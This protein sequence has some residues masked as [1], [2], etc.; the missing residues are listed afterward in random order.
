MTAATLQSI[1]ITAPN[2]SIAKGT[3]EQF[4]ATGTYSDASTANITSQVSWNSATP[5][6][7]TISTTGLAAG[8]G[9]GSSHI[10]A[11]LSGV[12]SNIFTL[13][14]TPATLRSIAI[15]ALNSSI[16]KGT[17][18]QFTATGTY[19]DASTAN[20]T[21]QV[22]W[23]SATPAVVTIS[24]TGLASGV[25]T[26]SSNITATLSSVTSNTFTL[27][28]LPAT[29]RSIAIT[30]PNTS[31]GKGI[32]EQFTATGTYSDASTAN[33]TSLA[34][35]NSATP[36]VVTISAIGLAS[37]VSTG[38][39]NI[40]ATLSSVTSNTFTLTVTAAQTCHYVT[41]NLSPS[42]VAQGSL[43]TVTG[44][45]RSCASTTQIVVT[46]FT[47]SGPAQPDSCSSTKSEMFTTPPFALP[48]NTQK[49]VSFP[50]RVPNNTC[51][52]SYTITA[53]TLVN[54][55]AVDTS[56]TAL[57]VTAH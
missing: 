30:A 25:S 51:P 5:A 29:L 53:T 57:T 12:T 22:N 8:A 10:T 45:L 17:S 13:T 41:I 32:S 9:T 39:S 27:T 15:T 1:A 42:S 3:S 28:V 37:G 35:W 2:S 6:V 24:A 54:G 23:N 34:S 19:S 38:S 40:T 46:K 55:H 47:L 36:A 50:F 48:P 26:G 33:I 52:G 31:I 7:V 4:T 16:A 14:V 11:T 21:S 20:I 49:T 18:E 44:T 56:S 43:I